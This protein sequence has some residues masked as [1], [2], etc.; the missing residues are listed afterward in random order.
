MTGAAS[1]ASGRRSGTVEEFDEA[2][3]LGFVK[4]A[5]AG[6]ER[7]RFHCTQIADG[8]RSIEVGT[9]ISF[10]VVPGRGGEWEAGDL[11]PL[12]G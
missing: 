9:R 7:Y 5:G 1:L 10:V 12:A 3:G 8:S 11:L 4:A 2:V 6:P